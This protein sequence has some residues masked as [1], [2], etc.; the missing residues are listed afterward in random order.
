MWHFAL[1]IYVERDTMY[2]LCRAGA[3]T[4]GGK[5]SAVQHS[6]EL[7]LWYARMYNGHSV[8][9]SAHSLLTSLAAACEEQALEQLS[10]RSPQPPRAQGRD[11]SH[12]HKE[13]ALLGPPA[14]REPECSS[15]LQD[16]EKRSGFEPL[17]D[18]LWGVNKKPGFCSE[19][20]LWVLDPNAGS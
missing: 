3:Q 1:L 2:T 18:V 7:P 16:R 9:A 14:Q 20:W 19:V 13:P 11:H 6:R 12:C 10:R 5:S 15:W 4:Q 8:P 17:G